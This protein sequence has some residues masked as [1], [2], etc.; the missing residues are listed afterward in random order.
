M[1]SIPSSSRSTS[2][3]FATSA[4]CRKRSPASRRNNS[5]RRPRKRSRAE[6]LHHLPDLLGHV[7]RQPQR[8]AP[9]LPSHATFCPPPFHVHPLT[10]GI[11][12]VTIAAGTR[13]R[14]HAARPV[15]FAIFFEL[16]GLGG[17]HC[18]AGRRWSVAP[19]HD[20]RVTSRR[21]LG[22]GSSAMAINKS[23]KVPLARREL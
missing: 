12:C 18:A 19:I 9:V 21:T 5:Y 4:S 8:L 7:R 22:G 15:S 11:A 1:R 10:A 13:G 3:R 20:G 23:R 17:R 6:L 2:A 16:S 14:F